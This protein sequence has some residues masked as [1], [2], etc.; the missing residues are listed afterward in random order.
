MALVLCK[1]K[2]LPGFQSS[3]IYRILLS[4]LN[5]GRRVYLWLQQ[6]AM[7]TVLEEILTRGSA[8][9]NVLLQGWQGD[10]TLLDFRLL[11]VNWPSPYPPSA[12]GVDVSDY[13]PPDDCRYARALVSREITALDLQE[14]MLS[15]EIDEASAEEANAEAGVSRATEE[16][17]EAEAELSRVQMEGP[18]NHRKRDPIDKVGVT[19]V[20][21]GML[22]YQTHWYL[23]RCSH[24]GVA[25]LV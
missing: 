18:A 3:A 17:S 2:K 23:H 25:F 24:H 14:A 9:N 13:L 16:V 22:E 21:L 20:A 12:S 8:E 10:S 7:R 5:K 15:Q 6:I 1:V 4:L 11:H 19:L